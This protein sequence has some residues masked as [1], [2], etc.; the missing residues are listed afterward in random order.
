MVDV[1]V[2]MLAAEKRCR[3]FRMNHLPWSPVIGMWMRRLKL[4]LFK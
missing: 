4:F 2:Y 1:R 3:K